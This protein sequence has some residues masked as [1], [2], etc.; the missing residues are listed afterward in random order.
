MAPLRLAVVGHVEHVSLGR[1]PV[2]PRP[3]EVTH[4]DDVVTFPGGGGGMAFFQLQKSAAQVQLFSAVGSDAVGHEIEARL[5]STGAEVH[6]ARR[7]EPHTRD[8]VLVTPDAERTIVVL[9]QPLHPEH[10]DPLPW[11]HLGD[12]DAVYFTARDPELLRL[13][14]RARLLVVSARRRE[15]LVSSGVRAD[16]VIGSRHDTRE[17]STLA[18]YPVAPA[19]L[20]LTEGA[21]GGV[22]HTAAGVA[23]F[24]APPS[25]AIV[26]SSYGAGDSFAAA[27]VYH[28]AAGAEVVDA[29]TRAGPHG[30]AVLSGLDAVAEQRRL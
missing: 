10:R 6:L 24:S 9:G 28:L 15:A 29:C 5:L 23:R 18:D 12:S 8:I 1:V 11:E 25:P 4:L 27:L 30:A 14:R 26:R 22:V 20:V 3:G 16:V 13:A 21:R 7:V 19:A 17:V 2:V